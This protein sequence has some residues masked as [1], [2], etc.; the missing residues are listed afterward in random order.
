MNRPFLSVVLTT[1]VCS[2]HFGNVPSAG[3][4]VIRAQTNTGKLNF[5]VQQSMNWFSEKALARPN[6]IRETINT[7]NNNG[8][9]SHNFDDFDFGICYL[10]SNFKGS[11]IRF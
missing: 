5:L 1:Y 6:T 2:D 4:I 10:L 3:I 11:N 8:I 9:I 7:R